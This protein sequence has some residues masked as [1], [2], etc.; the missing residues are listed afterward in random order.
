MIPHLHL[1]LEPEERK[2]RSAGR[3]P[4]RF[5]S[6]DQFFAAHSLENGD[7]MAV[8]LADIPRFLDELH[9]EQRRDGVGYAEVRISPRRF[10][11]D[12]C[13]LD[14]VLTAAHEAVSHKTDPVIRLVLLVNRDSSVQ[15]IER[16]ASQV[17]DGVPGT[18]VGVDI[19]GDETRFPD[20]RHLTVLTNA[21]RGRRLGI[22]V[23]AGEF[24]DSTHIWRALD[25]L[26]AS[27]IGH[28]VSAR[29]D[30]ALLSR[31]AS[32]KVLL[33]T[34]VT[35]NLA[36]GAVADGAIH[37]VRKFLDWGVPFCLNADVPIHVGS[38]L[39]A[40]M[41]MVAG[42]LDLDLASVIQLQMS[43]V[44]YGFLKPPTDSPER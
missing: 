32:D 10:V 30:S 27:R 24:G 18:V 35:T 22:T 43:A 15:F 39:Q 13:T 29:D 41:R 17:L 12:G 9:S 23:H 34:S 40:E 21:A 3:D 31:L 28:G 33:E 37:P 1:H 4:R 5:V 11:R 38:N 7:R 14:D 26:G 42:I 19:A 8:S 6:R 16:V 2:R 36:L 44:S 25:E 20:V